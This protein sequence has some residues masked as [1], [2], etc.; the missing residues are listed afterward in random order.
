VNAI[1]PGYL[2]TELNTTFWDSEAGKAM[3][4]R[5]PRR[6]LG[7]L[8]DLQTRHAGGELLKLLLSMRLQDPWMA[9]STVDKTRARDN[10][11]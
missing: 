4:R 1:A 9:T 8:E 3:T 7:R 10:H 2:D 6:R 11:S 5:I